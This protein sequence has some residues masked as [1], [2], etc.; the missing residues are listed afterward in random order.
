MSANSPLI[1]LLTSLTGTMGNASPK[2]NGDGSWGCLAVP[3][4]GGGVHYVCCGLIF[5]STIP[6]IGKFKSLTSP[7]LPP[8][9]RGGRLVTQQQYCVQ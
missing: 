4:P 1:I 5:V 9:Q 3:C 7:R 2:T 8:V 6:I